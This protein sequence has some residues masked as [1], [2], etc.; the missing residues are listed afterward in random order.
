[1]PRYI[2]E[3]TVGQL[4]QEEWNQVGEKSN[5]A[6]RELGGGVVWVRSYI[7]HAEGKVYCEYDAPSK[8]TVI[9][10]SRMAGMPI[11]QISEINFEI[12]PTMF[13]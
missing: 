10:L 1:M 4:T 6:I 12:S 3:R 8:E 11:D 2:V 13:V 7:S 9:E 5:A